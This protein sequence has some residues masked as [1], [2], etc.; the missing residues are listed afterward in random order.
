MY[1]PVNG[2]FQGSGRPLG[3]GFSDPEGIARLGV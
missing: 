1:N 3:S 2:T